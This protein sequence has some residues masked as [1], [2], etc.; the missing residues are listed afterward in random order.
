MSVIA[1]KKYDDRIEVAC[2]TA[3]TL[4]PLT[5]P[6]GILNKITYYEEHGALVGVTGYARHISAI[7]YFSHKNKMWK[8][9]E[10]PLCVR[11]GEEMKNCCGD[12]DDGSE[13]ILIK[14]GKI[15]LIEKWLPIEINDYIS[16]GS[17]ANYAECLMHIGKSPEESVK[18]AMELNCYC[19]GDV[20]VF[21]V[22]LKKELSA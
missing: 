1:A 10:V 15:F 18:V 9:H 21:N 8:Q 5:K 4:G 11:I 20:K 6:K 19:D 22:P 7:D 3:L 17:G 14:D 12:E 16:I 2:D 13:I